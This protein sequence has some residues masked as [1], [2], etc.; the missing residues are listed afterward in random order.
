M[1]NGQKINKLI[2]ERHITKKSLFEYMG[3]SA[4]GLDSIIKN[5]NPTAEK[6]EQIADFFQ[7]PIDYFF[8]R[9]NPGNITSIG[10]QITGDGNRV[11]GD[12]GL[13]ECKKEIEHLRQ[14]LEEKEKAIAD[15]ERTIQILMKQYK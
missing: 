14:L 3:T 5:C 15:K 12:I 10:H 13:S 4:S 11:T 7:L 6:I 2:E 8:D 9:N 1:F